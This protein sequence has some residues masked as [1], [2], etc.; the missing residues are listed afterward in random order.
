MISDISDVNYNLYLC[1]I[2]NH[3]IITINR[4]NNL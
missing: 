2:V 4:I 3:C 1:A